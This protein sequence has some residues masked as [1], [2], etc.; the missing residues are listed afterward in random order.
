[1]RLC[2]A[3]RPHTQTRSHHTPDGGDPSLS[4]QTYSHD[5]IHKGKQENLRH[6]AKEEDR[7]VGRKYDAC[8]KQMLTPTTTESRISGIAMC[9]S[10]AYQPTRND[11]EALAMMTQVH[12]STR[13][14]E[15]EEPRS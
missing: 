10:L 5:I 9:W 8:R 7:V 6:A 4:A 15:P 1:M 13:N 3:M 14:V 11:L 2:T 12:H